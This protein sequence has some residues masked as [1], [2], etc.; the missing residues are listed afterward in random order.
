MGDDSRDPRAGAV[1]DLPTGYRGEC[2]GGCRD[3]AAVDCTSED[4]NEVLRHRSHFSQLP[5]FFV[6]S[7]KFNIPVH[8][9]MDAK[10]LV[11]SQDRYVNESD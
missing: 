5:E 1:A 6:I 7:A 3:V 8:L 11:V 2:D 4:P 10:W 9:D